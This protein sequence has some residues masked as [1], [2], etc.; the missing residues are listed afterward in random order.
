MTCRGTCFDVALSLIHDMNNP[1]NSGI[2]AWGAIGYF[3]CT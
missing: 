3:L 2:W 1:K